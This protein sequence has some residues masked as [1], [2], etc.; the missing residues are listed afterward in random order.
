[1]LTCLN[2]KKLQNEIF[3]FLHRGKVGSSVLGHGFHVGVDKTSDLQ[4][5]FLQE[6]ISKSGHQ[7][8]GQLGLK[9]ND[10]SDHTELWAESLIHKQLNSYF[11][12]LIHKDEC[13]L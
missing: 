4:I 12:D 8:H 6:D 5:G 9:Q 2:G 7:T 10:S 1:M 3:Q 13:Y 11:L